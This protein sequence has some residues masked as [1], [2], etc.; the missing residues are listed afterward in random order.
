MAISNVQT[1]IQDNVDTSLSPSEPKNKLSV[2]LSQLPDGSGY[3]YGLVK[4]SNWESRR[5][6]ILLP[7]YEMKRIS[8]EHGF[9][10]QAPK[11]T[12]EKLYIIYLDGEEV[13]RMEKLQDFHSPKL[14]E[15]K[16]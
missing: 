11:T 16:A 6:D 14:L 1:G 13:A 15:K 8:R 5:V 4:S 3:I 9:P 10:I 2:H 7:R 12:D